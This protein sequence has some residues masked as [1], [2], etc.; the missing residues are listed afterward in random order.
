MLTN[1]YKYN[2]LRMEVN[3]TLLLVSKDMQ[4]CSFHI[5]FLHIE[6][7]LKHIRFRKMF[8][9]RYWQR[10][11]EENLSLDYVLLCIII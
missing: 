5:A 3:F 9:H 8:T 11:K 1:A 6:S 10:V 2:N 7:I 4:S